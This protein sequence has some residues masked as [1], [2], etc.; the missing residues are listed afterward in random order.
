MKVYDGGGKVYSQAEKFGQFISLNAKPFMKGA[1]YNVLLKREI[2]KTVESV[3][4]ENCGGN[5]YRVPGIESR[6]MN[7][8]GIY[9]TAPGDVI[10]IERV[11]DESGEEF[12]VEQYRL[13]LAYIPPF[14]TSSSCLPCSAIHPLSITI[15]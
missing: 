5:Y 14:F 15:I 3:V 6:R 11:F 4:L 2:A 7:I 9:Y 13:N 1:Y 12:K 8:D 10:S